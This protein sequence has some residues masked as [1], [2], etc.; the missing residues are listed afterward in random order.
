MRHV[1]SRSLIAVVLL[2]AAAGPAAANVCVNIDESRDMFSAQD[3]V[4]SLLLLAKEFQLAGEQVVSD[5]CTEFYALSHVRLG[6][7]IIATLSGPNAQREGRAQ[8]M[9]DLP[10]LYNQ[11]VRSIIT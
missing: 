6:T 4:A 1:I 5:G 11:M 3:R 10:A 2:F 9:D 7:I 8:G